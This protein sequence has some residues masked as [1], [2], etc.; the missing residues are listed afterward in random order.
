MYPSFYCAVNFHRKDFSMVFSSK[1]IRSL[2]KPVI[3]TIIIIIVLYIFS[4]IK[5]FTHASVTRYVQK[6]QLELNSYVEQVLKDRPI[7]Q[8]TYN[9]WK[10]TYNFG[11]QQIDFSVGGFGLAPSS[12]YWGFYYTPDDIPIGIDGS[13]VLLSPDGNGWSW[14]EPNGDNSQYIEKIC[15]NWYWYKAS[16]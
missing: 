14:K 13:N 10:V 11:T 15:N 2:L 6:H 12:T 4:C 7:K 16:L 1:K 9:G 5:P 8:G 3:A